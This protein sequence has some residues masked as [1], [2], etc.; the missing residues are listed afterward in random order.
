MDSQQNGEQNDGFS[1][2]GRSNL[3]NIMQKIPKAILE[4]TKDTNLL[5]TKNNLID[6]SMAE[7]WLIRP[8]VLEICKSAIQNNFESH[9]RISILKLLNRGY[10]HILIWLGFELAYWFLGRFI[11]NHR[12]RK[13]L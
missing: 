8:E 11:I 5:S 6:L 9:V 12:A 2:R 4:G 13:I 7:N 3:T 10:V 1:S